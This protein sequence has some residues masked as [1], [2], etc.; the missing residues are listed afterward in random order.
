MKTPQIDP[1]PSSNNIQVYFK[2][3][4]Q[5]SIWKSFVKAKGIWKE[6]KWIIWQ[7]MF[8]SN[9]SNGCRHMNLQPLVKH[10][11]V[12]TLLWR[13]EVKVSYSN[14]MEK[15]VFL[16]ILTTVS[17][18]TNKLLPSSTKAA[19]QKRIQCESKKKYGFFKPIVTFSKNL[20]Y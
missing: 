9:I 20:L 17:F 10:R 16:S 4:N 7:K 8:K 6:N 19:Q 12:I 18:F 5:F 11:Q 13:I 1:L 14:R 2:T 3:V 15:S